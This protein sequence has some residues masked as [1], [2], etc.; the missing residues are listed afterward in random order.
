MADGATDEGLSFFSQR[1]AFLG[2]VGAS[3]CSLMAHGVGRDRQSAERIIIVGGGLSG[4][5]A[6]LELGER[7]YAVTVVEA[8]E[9]IGGRVHTLRQPFTNGLYAEAGGEII[10]D[11]YRRL[12]AY[13]RRFGLETEPLG[14]G[15]T[16]A[17]VAYM[18]G[19]WYRFGDEPHPYGLRGKEMRLSPPELLLDHL[20]A[21][22]AEVGTDW[23]QLARYDG[24]SLAT[25]LAKGGASPSAVRLINIALNYNDVHTVSAA[26]ALFDLLRRMEGGQRAL[27][28]RGG[29]DLL[30]QAMAAAIERR[31]GRL[32]TGAI[33]HRV[34]HMP[35]GVRL[36][37]E[38]NGRA[39]ELEAERVIFSVP[40][41]T[42]RRVIFDPALPTAKAQAIAAVPYTRVTKIFFEGERVCWD[43]GQ[44]GAGLWTDTP[45]ERIVLVPT[46][47]NT[48][49]LFVAWIDG[50]GAEMPDQMDERTR[51]T[52]ASELFSQVLPECGRRSRAVATVSWASDPWARGAY[53]HF[54]PGQWV[55]IRPL[56]ASSVGRMHFCGEHTADHAS[57]MEGAL[58]S[59]ARVVR[60]IAGADP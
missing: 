7:G 50:N 49:T 48:R 31:G 21:C 13:A 30:P 15:A 2:A 47:H 23:S 1:R 40:A 32:I 42:L 43:E 53:A 33:A 10:G 54:A 20:H 27:R 52:W 17:R 24:W 29:N 56:L 8:R 51:M 18:R 5:A 11:R 38:K 39:Q 4:L 25:L 22:I 37:V 14:E 44:F 34:R 35:V 55:A 6:A 28:L 57:G 16:R 46:L 3:L 9:R 19:R 58:G 59:A 36:T 41:T 12:L 26:S 60:E 45:L